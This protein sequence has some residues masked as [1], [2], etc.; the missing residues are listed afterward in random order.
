MEIDADVYV[1]ADADMTY[2]ADRVHDL[3]QPILAGE[4][5]MTVGDRHSGGH[6]AQENDGLCTGSETPL[7]KG[8]F[9]RFFNAKLAD[10]MSGYRVFNRRF[11]KS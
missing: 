6:Y 7:Y 11:V 2:P 8:W 4:A 10:I 1:L 9:N 3:M 5:D